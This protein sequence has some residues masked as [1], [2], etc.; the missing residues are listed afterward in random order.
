MTEHKDHRHVEEKRCQNDEIGSASQSDGHR[1]EYCGYRTVHPSK[2]KCHVRA[3]HLKMRDYKCEHC[4]REFSFK[5]NLSAHVKTMHE[6]VTHLCD[7]DRC[8]HRAASS[9][10]LKQH[11]RSVHLKLAEYVCKH[12]HAKLGS[13]VTLHRHVKTIHKGVK[14]GVSYKHS[15]NQCDYRTGNAASLKAHNKT[16]HLI[17]H[18]CEQCRANFASIDNLK[19]HVKVKHEGFR[20]CCEQCNFKT[21]NKTYLKNHVN[22]VHFKVNGHTCKDCRMEFATRHGLNYHAKAK[23]DGIKPAVK[24]K[25]SCDQCAYDSTSLKTHARSTHLKINNHTCEQCQANF[26]S[27]HSLNWHVTMLHNGF[28]HCCERCDFKTS[29]R[30]YLR[31]HVNAVHL[32]VATRQGLKRHATVAKHE[33]LDDSEDR[34]YRPP[35]A[36]GLKGTR[37]SLRSRASKSL[38][39][40]DGVQEEEES[41]HVVLAEASVKT[42]DARRMVREK[43]EEEEEDPLGGEGFISMM[44]K[45]EG[46]EEE[47]GEHHLTVKEEEEE[48][49]LRL[50]EKED[51]LDVEEEGHPLTVKEEEEKEDNETALMLTE[52]EE[53]LDVEEDED[54]VDMEQFVLS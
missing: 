37:R 7:R 6:G 43:G 25:D 31:N 11:I 26:L 5:S 50:T 23:H 21:S 45:E 14:T 54:C 38:A 49:A 48:P 10:L 39:A 17:D 51:A 30:T 44:V 2:L 36:V 42:E 32:K 33:G 47:E 24:Y 46:E 20:Y 40:S 1:C 41:P 9:D 15:C 22:S 27:S 53:A 29:N 13:K 8:D 28:R 19:W 52:A 18:T 3:K 12:C 35:R 16:V 34:D 4:D